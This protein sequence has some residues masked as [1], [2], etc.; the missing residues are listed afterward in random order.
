MFKRAACKAL[1]IPVGGVVWPRLISSPAIAALGTLAAAWPLLA[2]IFSV[3]LH[4]VIGCHRLGAPNPSHLQQLD[5]SCCHPDSGGRCQ[6]LGI[7]PHFG[8][9]IGESCAGCCLLWEGRLPWGHF[10]PVCPITSLCHLQSSRQ[11]P[12]VSFSSYCL[13]PSWTLPWGL[14]STTH[15]RVQTDQSGIG[16]RL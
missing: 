16:P 13:C 9:L 14:R 12:L 2:K 5:A 11:T 3:V 1:W 8:E 15:S 7:H 6:D 4:E 10:C